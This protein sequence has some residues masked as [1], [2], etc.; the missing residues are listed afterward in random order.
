MAHSTFDPTKVRGSRPPADGETGLVRGAVS[1][2]R[3]GEGECLQFIYVRFAADVRYHVGELIADGGRI[4]EVTQEVF[5]S[6]PSRIDEYQEADTP[7]ESWLTG[8]AR[9]VA[10]RNRTRQPL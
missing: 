1:G 3:R 2:A 8:F 6:L 5:T 7:F 9:T 4:D 10:R